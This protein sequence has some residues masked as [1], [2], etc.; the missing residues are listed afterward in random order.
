MTV[1]TGLDLSLTST[2]W[3]TITDSGD[4]TT[5]RIQSKGAKTATLDERARRLRELTASVVDL[6]DRTDLVVLEGP[7]FGQHRQSGQH[8]RAGLWWLVTAAL[9][10]EYVDHV[11]DVPPAV[12]KKYATGKGNADKDTVLLAVARRFPHV[13]ITGNDE[14]DALILA[15]MGARHAGHPIDDMPL[16]H[17]TAMAKVAWPQPAE[18]PF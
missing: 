8:D 6:C 14:A 16:T 9:L 17:T 11:V 5:G 7:S 1:I 4:V 12:V 10:D 13:D 15:A 2:G 3:A 18:V